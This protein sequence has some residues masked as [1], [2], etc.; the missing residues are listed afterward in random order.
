M[1]DITQEH[2]DR[3]VD[4]CFNLIEGDIFGPENEGGFTST[5]DEKIKTSI[6]AVF[7]SALTERQQHIKRIEELEGAL[8]LIE[9]ALKG[10]DEPFLVGLKVTAR[11]ALSTNEDKGD[12]K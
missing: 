4:N 3:M 5:M 1:S 9:A 8:R 7:R 12:S 2:I 6:R 10:E 11:Q